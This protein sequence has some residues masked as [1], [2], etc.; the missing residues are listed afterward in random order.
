MIRFP[1]ASLSDMVRRET[2]SLNA[3][4]ADVQAQAISGLAL[5][6]PSDDPVGVVAAQR[7]SAAVADQDVWIANA[8]RAV[9]VHDV[10]DTALGGVNDLLVRARELAVAMASETADG[11]ARAIAAV[12][13]QGLRDAVVSAANTRY[14]GR[15]VF[16]GA[17]WDAEP[18][19]ADGTYSGDTSAPTARVG[20]DRWV[21]VGFDGS[22]FFAGDVDIF[23]TLSALVTA[24]ETNDAAGVA[25]T[26]DGLDVAT[27]Q[28]AGARGEVGVQTQIA[29]DAA[30]VAESMGVVFG[31]RLASLVQADPVETYTKLNELQSAYTSTLQVAA[32]A[33]TKS[34]LD[35]LG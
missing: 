10:A 9:G 26:L 19:A 23:A 21:E 33:T 20:E 5:Q 35:Y 30:T 24:L 25:A 14:D 32:S 27:D 17:A 11:E 2:A 6:R 18:F 3:R 12:E 1:R 28:I 8:E 34:L 16:G 31:E 7:M 22:A 4:I 29:E 15:Y 13:A